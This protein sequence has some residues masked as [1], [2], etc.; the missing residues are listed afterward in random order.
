MCSKIIVYSM[1]II[2]KAISKPFLASLNKYAIGCL[3]LVKLS[4]H[5]TLPI[6]ILNRKHETG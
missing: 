1:N 5:M 3:S 2:Y 6:I 4:I